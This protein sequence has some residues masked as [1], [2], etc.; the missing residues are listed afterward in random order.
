MKSLL[1]SFTTCYFMLTGIS[2]AQIVEKEIK[3]ANVLKGIDQIAN[4]SEQLNN[5]KVGVVTNQ[6]SLIKNVHLI[7]TLINLNIDVKCVFAPEHGFRGDHDAGA[8]V[9]NGV[10]SKTGLPIFSLHG[11]YKKP[12]KEWIDSLDI[13]LFDIQDVGVRFYTYISTLHYVMEAA[14]ENNIKVILLDRPN[15]HDYYVDG[16]VLKSK[17][18]SFVGMHPVPVVYG[19]TIGEYGVMINGEFWLKDSVQCDLE[20]ISIKNYKRGSWDL[21]EVPP[22]PNLPNV[23]SVKLYPSLCFFEGTVISAGRGTDFPFQVYGAPD[24]KGYSFKFT[25]IS[26]PGFSRYPKFENQQCIGEDLRQTD[27]KS[28]KNINWNY[29]IK[30]YNNSNNKDSFFLKND[31]INLLT[32]T[33]QIRAWI[34]SSNESKDIRHH[35]QEEL[36]GFKLIRNK[37]LN[38]SY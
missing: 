19:M 10:D 17:F 35:Y 20:V 36:Q 23:Q 38:P 1:L 32:G 6:T 7:D 3:E 13:I 15:L 25:P 30:A 14:A 9:E 27:V 26:K 12:K 34:E 2:C 16:P 11:K 4:W 18:R 22:S 29:L 24:L 5:K 8:N 21:L 37:Y 31:F 28:V 33:E